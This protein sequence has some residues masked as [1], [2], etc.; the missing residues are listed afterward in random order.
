MSNKIKSIAV[1]G[2]GTMGAGIAALAADKGCNVLLL[3]ISLEAAENGK[4][5]MVSD[6]GPLLND[7]NKISNVKIGTFNDNFED[8]V[9]YDWICEVVVE[10]LDIKRQIFQKIESFRKDGSIVSSN[11]SGIPLRDITEGM[12]SRLLNDVC[13]THFFNPVKV[14]K[15]CEV[16]PG[17]KTS[18]IILDELKM[19]IT[20]VLQKGV[21]NAKDTVNFIGNRIGCYWMLRGL[22]EGKTSRELGVIKSKFQMNLSQNLYCLSC[23]QQL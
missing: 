15:L 17:E 9:E 18:K 4:N 13:I 10:K 1:L 6:R 20:D 3:D 21:V 14:M 7:L 11:T 2:A 19:F 5:L 8:I 22:H 16:I 23:S 12:P